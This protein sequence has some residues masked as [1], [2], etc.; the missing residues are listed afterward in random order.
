MFHPPS[1]SSLLR[2]LHSNLANL[3]TTQL[4]SCNT[5]MFLHFRK[6]KSAYIAY[7]NENHSELPALLFPIPNSWLKSVEYLDTHLNN[8]IHFLKAESNYSNVHTEAILEMFQSKN[9]A[10]QLTLQVTSISKI[11]RFIT[12]LEGSKYPYS[13]KLWDELPTLNGCM[14]HYADGAFP[15]RTQEALGDCGILTQ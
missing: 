11:T 13:Q 12:E 5:P 3:P 2:P 7:L 10:K 15:Q 14:Q 9:I 1:Q 4:P 8:I 6:M